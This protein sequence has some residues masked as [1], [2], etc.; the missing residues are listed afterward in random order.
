MHS[1]QVS[2]IIPMYNQ[3]KYVGRCLRSLLKQ[4][5]PEGDY[6]IIVINDGST[7]NSVEALKPFMGDIRYHKNEERLGLPA[8]LNIAIKKARGQFIVR[9]DADDFVHWDYLKIL[10]MHL[11]MN[12]DIDAIACDYQLVNDEQEVLERGVNCLERPIGCGIMF[13]LDHLIEVGLYDEGFLVR[14]EEDLRIRFLKKYDISRVQ[15][16]LYRYRQHNNNIT[17]N[18]ENMD[19]F[20]KK[21]DDKHNGEE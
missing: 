4:T 3:E 5:I 17:N 11:Q 8:S 18:L 10:S 9:V 20:Q 14:E 16:P 6:E 2:V 21:L 1:Y 13:K 12:H 15:L 7:D 19:T